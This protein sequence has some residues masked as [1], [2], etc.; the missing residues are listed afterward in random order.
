MV[1]VACF[2]FLPLF[3]KPAVYSEEKYGRQNHMV[4][5]ISLLKKMNYIISRELP[6]VRQCEPELHAMLL[7]GRRQSEVAKLDVDVI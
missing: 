5:K 6:M 7:P 1:P 2:L 3:D 4:I